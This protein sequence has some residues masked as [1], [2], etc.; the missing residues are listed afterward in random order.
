MNKTQYL[1][2][3]DRE[4]SRHRRKLGRACRS[5]KIVVVT[6]RRA[7]KLNR[8]IMN[9]TR[10]QETRREFK[11]LQPTERVRIHH[12]SPV[13]TR[14]F[15]QP[16]EPIPRDSYEHISSA[17]PCVTLLFPFFTLFCLE[18]TIAICLYF[19]RLFHVLR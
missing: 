7:C 10:K 6:R 1:T 18:L 11:K 12:C 16:L 17:P 5:N 13:T 3:K 19:Q 8:K 2:L 4:K 9:P 15:F 14:V